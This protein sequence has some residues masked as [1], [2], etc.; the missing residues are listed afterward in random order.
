MNNE[1]GRCISE[2]K[3]TKCFMEEG[4]IVSDAAYG[5][6]KMKTE[7]GPFNLATWCLLVILTGTLFRWRDGN[8]CLS[9]ASSRKNGRSGSGEEVTTTLSKSFI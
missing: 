7:T 5:S 9:R 2:A 3:R 1:L 6:N 8:K 4:V